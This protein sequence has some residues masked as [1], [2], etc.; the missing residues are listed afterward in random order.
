M[1]EYGKENLCSEEVNQFEIPDLAEIKD[2]LTLFL[3]FVLS[4][5]LL[6]EHLFLLNKQQQELSFLWV[7]ALAVFFSVTT[8]ATYCKP[9]FRQFFL[10]NVPLISVF[11]VMLMFW[12][13]LSIKFGV[14]SMF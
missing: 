12:N 8:I 11:I 13:L 6:M 1:V 10:V 9:K 7:G 2:N 14:L 4:F 3:P 5:L